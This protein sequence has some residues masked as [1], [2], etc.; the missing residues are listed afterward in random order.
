M[1]KGEGGPS[2]PLEL[3]SLI[4]DSFATQPHDFLPAEEKHR[5]PEEVWRGTGQRER[6]LLRVLRLVREY[7]SDMAHLQCS[8]LLQR[9]A[10]VCQARTLK[11]ENLHM[12]AAR[13]GTKDRKTGLAMR[14]HIR[15][16]HGEW[17]SC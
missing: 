12:K 16:C 7:G 9:S 3:I 13:Y 14:S 17:G 6:K 2:H 15:G 10:V 5:I 4:F 11:E 8:V 1:P